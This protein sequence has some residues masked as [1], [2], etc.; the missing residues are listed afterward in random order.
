MENIRLELNENGEGAFLL[1]ESDRKIGE[2][3]LRIEN[4]IM[5]V[6]HTE[7]APEAEGKG[8]AGQLLAAMVDHAR[9]NQLKVVPLCPYVQMQFRRHPDKY[10]EIWQKPSDN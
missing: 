6:F 8:Y 9:N 3:A 4:G 7:V 5:T 1:T 2:M 10:K